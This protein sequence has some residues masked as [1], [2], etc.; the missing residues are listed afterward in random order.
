MTELEPRL[1]GCV[2]LQCGITGTRN[3]SM[4]WNYWRVESAGC[5]LTPKVESAGCILTPKRIN[6]GQ[7]YSEGARGTPSGT[8]R[9]RGKLVSVFSCNVRTLSALFPSLTPPRNAKVRPWR[10]TKGCQDGLLTKA[11]QDSG[12][13]RRGTHCVLTKP[14]WALWLSRSTPSQPR[15]LICAR[16][17][18]TAGSSTCGGNGASI[19]GPANKANLC[20]CPLT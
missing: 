8:R 6:S 2:V 16:S 13:S 17:E 5:I 11:C 10:P 4:S 14:L 15:W 20:K 3:R 7:L 9:A 19:W 18:V 1:A 12:C